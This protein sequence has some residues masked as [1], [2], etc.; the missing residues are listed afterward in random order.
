MNKEESK[1]LAELWAKREINMANNNLDQIAGNFAP[2]VKIGW[3]EINTRKKELNQ[4]KWWQFIKRKILN[5]EITEIRYVLFNIGLI[6][7][8]EDLEKMGILK[9]YPSKN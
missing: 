3:N 5:S 8:M 4:L 7:G 1:K 2:V 9:K 6:K